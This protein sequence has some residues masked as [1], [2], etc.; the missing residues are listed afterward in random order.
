MI[1]L[2]KDKSAFGSYEEYKLIWDPNTSLWKEIKNF[3]RWSIHWIDNESTGNTYPRWIEDVQ[4][5]RCMRHFYQLKRS[6]EMY[7][8]YK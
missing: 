3:A 8:K 7:P 6:N 5:M 2:G 4:E 1:Y